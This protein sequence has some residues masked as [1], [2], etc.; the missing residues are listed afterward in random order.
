M[1]EAVAGGTR[2]LEEQDRG[3]GPC[4]GRLIRQHGFS[5]SFSGSFFPLSLRLL[6]VEPCCR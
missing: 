5:S 6:I 2:M 4:H 3:L 1:F